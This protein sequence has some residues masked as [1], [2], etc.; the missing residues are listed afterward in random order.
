MGSAHVH[1]LLGACCTQQQQQQHLG[2]ACWHDTDTLHRVRHLPHCDRCRLTQLYSNSL[3]RQPWLSNCCLASEVQVHG[4][5]ER[6]AMNPCF[7]FVVNTNTAH[8][9][10]AIPFLTM[11]A[12]KHTCYSRQIRSDH[13]SAVINCH[14][15]M[16]IFKY[17]QWHSTGVCLE[18]GSRLK[19]LPPPS[20]P[21]TGIRVMTAPILFCY[22][23][24]GWLH[25]QLSRWN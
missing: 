25:K 20:L 6:L 19:L 5:N 13:R 24:P 21:I 7:C 2:S 17:W 14:S 10:R 23:Q 15:V 11:A 1:S 4:H 16:H 9:R 12:E 18:L 3:A 8:M 22:H